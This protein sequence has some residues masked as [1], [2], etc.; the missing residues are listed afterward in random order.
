MMACFWETMHA[1]VH[2]DSKLRLFSEFV[3]TNPR[4][5]TERQSPRLPLRRPGLHTLNPIRLS[6]PRRI[7]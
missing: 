1:R 5:P 6:L 2:R 3:A 4:E 7:P